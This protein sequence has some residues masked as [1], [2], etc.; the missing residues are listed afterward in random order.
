L[1]EVRELGRDGVVVDV[2]V[3]SELPQ[4]LLREV[5]EVAERGDHIADVSVCGREELELVRMQ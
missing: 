1:L 5:V 4:R 3:A 2:A